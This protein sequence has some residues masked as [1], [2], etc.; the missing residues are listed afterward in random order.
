MTDLRLRRSEERF[1]GGFFRKSVLP[2]L[3][4]LL[5]MIP[6]SSL[7]VHGETHCHGS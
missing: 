6:S 7:D 4:A 2:L 1:S 3:R 5:E